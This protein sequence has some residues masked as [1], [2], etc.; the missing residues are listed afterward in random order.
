MKRDLA[1]VAVLWLILTA[2]G[3]A[4][5]RLD[6]FPI[7][8][9]DKGEEIKHA[10]SVLMYFAA[11]VFAFVTAILVFSVLRYRRAGAPDTDGPPHLGRGLI[12][13]AWFGIT[14]ALAVTI[15]IY[16]GIIG[17]SRIMKDEPNP[18]VVVQVQ[19]T[20]WRWLI[21]YPQHQVMTISEVVLPVDQT[22]RFEVTAVDVI[23][24]VWIPAFLMKIDAVPGMVTT[25]TIRPTMLGAFETDESMRLQCAELCGRDH[26]LMTL[27]L[28]VVSAEEF[29]SW[30]K[31]QPPAQTGDFAPR[32][33]AGGS[34]H[35]R[36]R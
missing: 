10:F 29:Q 6:L 31:Q 9:A 14:A 5:A 35:Q 4:V 12:P 17:T 18:D 27:P 16:P 15:M 36:H 32:K 2:A 21:T 13:I 33:P 23:H 11:P 7:V 34:A 22:V 8:R 28:R 20:R 25:F 30:L 3:L 19:G 26:A 24:S 1:V